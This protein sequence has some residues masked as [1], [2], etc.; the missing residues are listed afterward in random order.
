MIGVIPQALVERELAHDGLTEL[1]VVES[2]HERKAL[3]AE[4]AD[5]SSRCPAGSGRST[6]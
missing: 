5:G 3:M 1:H 6:S 4:L 2:L